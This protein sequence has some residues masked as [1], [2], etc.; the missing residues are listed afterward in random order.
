MLKIII[1]DSS[2]EVGL[3]GQLSQLLIPSSTKFRP[4]ESQSP[5]RAVPPPLPLAARSRR[6]WLKP[7]SC[8]AWMMSGRPLLRQGLRGSRKSRFGNK[9]KFLQQFLVQSLLRPLR[10][11]RSRPSPPSRSLFL[12]WKPQV[13][14]EEEWGPPQAPPPSHAT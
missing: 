7:E 11:C 10:R 9:V 12:T 13:P 4:S 5:R 1:F 8:R 14:S 2:H 3:C 6:S